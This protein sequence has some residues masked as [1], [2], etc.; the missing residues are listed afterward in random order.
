MVKARI[1]SEPDGDYF[2]SINY[3]K[4]PPAGTE[5]SCRAYY[6]HLIDGWGPSHRCDREFAFQSGLFET[7]LRD[8]HLRCRTA[9]CGE[10]HHRPER[11]APVTT[12][13]AGAQRTF[14]SVDG[15]Y[16]PCERVPT[17][18]DYRIG[19]VST[20]VDV[21]KV[22]MLTRYFTECTNAQCKNCWCLY[23]CRI[24]CYSNIRQGTTFTKAMK[25]RL[26][27]EARRNTHH[28]LVHYCEMLERNPHAFDHMSRVIYSQRGVA[29]IQDISRVEQARRSKGSAE[30]VET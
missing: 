16:Y 18:E 24:G 30:G 7:M 8:V 19:S 28:A 13:V 14:V 26:C 11:Y 22:Y 29:V 1:E 12:C 25:E 27:G 10:H 6:G 9:H 20:G 17:H 21:E 5:E 3:P 15:H 2:D 4:G 23:M